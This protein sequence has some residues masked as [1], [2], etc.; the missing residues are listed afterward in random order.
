MAKVPSRKASN[1][2][3][4]RASLKDIQHLIQNSLGVGIDSD[5]KVDED[6]D[7]ETKLQVRFLLAFTHLESVTA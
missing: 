4:E 5:L 1:R 2:I 6:C 3:M 7:S